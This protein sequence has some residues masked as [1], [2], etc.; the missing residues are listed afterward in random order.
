MLTLLQAN[1]A[2]LLIQE[3][4][5]P[6][7]MSLIK[8]AVAGGWLMIVLLILSIIAIYILG[9]RLW[10]IR[11]AGKLDPHFMTNIRELVRA[12]KTSSAISLCRENSSPIARL[13]EKGLERQG[14]PLPDIQAAVENVANIEVAKLEKGLP[15]LA[16]VAGGAPMIGFLGTVI[17]MIQAFYNMASA[18]SNIDITLLS[19]G[20]YTAMV[21]TVGGLFVGIIAYFGYNWLTSRVNDIVFKMESETISLMDML[22][23][24]QTGTQP[25]H[26]G[27]TA[28]HRPAKRSTAGTARTA[29]TGTA[30]TAAPKPAGRSSRISGTGT[31]D[32]ASSAATPAASDASAASAAS[33]ADGNSETFTL[34]KD[35]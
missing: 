20:I 35:I 1:T 8:M 2:D 4:A 27:E 31:R 34:D 15:M 13:I 24:A 21:T 6:E 26:S 33:D 7:K 18:G 11:Q 22:S 9:N 23:S 30:R 28:S 19:G 14:N 25:E 29:A 5:A 10:A 16:T 12:G 3:A 17:G 32:T